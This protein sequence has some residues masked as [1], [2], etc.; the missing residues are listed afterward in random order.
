MWSEW[1]RLT[2]F[3][4]SARIGLLR[5]RR[6][7]ESVEVGQP[8]AAKL[9]T[10]D[11][12]RTYSVTVSQHLAALQDEHSLCSAVLV[13]S[14]ALAEMAA[15]E[16]LGIPE[17]HK[18]NGIETWGRRLLKKTSSSWPAVLDGMADGGEASTTSAALAPVSPAR[19]V[20]SN[21]EADCTPTELKMR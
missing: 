1:G 3:F 21:E 19:G 12:P 16:T 9:T 7:W 4:E 6:I 5:E 10:R 2:R 15:R 20:Q 14:Y 17:T 8:S 18:L 13:Y 11:G